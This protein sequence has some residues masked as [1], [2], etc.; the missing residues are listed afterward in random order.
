M[1][2][3]FHGPGGVLNKIIKITKEPLYAKKRC[4]NVQTTGLTM[5]LNNKIIANL[6][7]SLNGV[8][9]LFNVNKQKAVKNEI[10]RSYKTSLILFLT[11]LLSYHYRNLNI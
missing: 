2:A 6:N 9:D 7:W 5:F 8:Q 10:K 11:Y 4:Y 1:W 3:L